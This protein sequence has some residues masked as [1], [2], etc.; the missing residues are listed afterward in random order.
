MQPHPCVAEGLKWLYIMAFAPLARR[1]LASLCLGAATSEVKVPLFCPIP[2]KTRKQISLLKDA[3]SAATSSGSDLWF[4]LH[5]QS[6]HPSDLIQLLDDITTETQPLGS[7]F[8]PLISELQL[9]VDCAS[10]VSELFATELRG[11]A[12]FLNIFDSDDTRSDVLQ[13]VF[14]ANSGPIILAFGA[15]G[16]G[17]TF[18]TRQQCINMTLA[19]HLMMLRGQLPPLSFPALSP[20]LHSSLFGSTP[21]LP[22]S[23]SPVGP[24]GTP[25]SSSSPLSP[26]SSSSPAAPPLPSGSSLSSIGAQGYLLFSAS[27]NA[28]LSDMAQELHLDVLSNCA[29]LRNQPCIL[30]VV[31]QEEAQVL[32]MTPSEDAAEFTVESLTVNHN[33]PNSKNRLSRAM[34]HG[35]GRDRNVTTVLATAGLLSPPIIQEMRGQVFFLN[36]DEAQVINFVSTLSLMSTL[37]IDALPGIFPMVQAIGDGSQRIAHTPPSLR[38]HDP[39]KVSPCAQNF[40]PMLASSLLSQPITAPVTSTRHFLFLASAHIASLSP[41]STSFSSFP[42]APTSFPPKSGLGAIDLPPIAPALPPSSSD[43]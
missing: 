34:A 26:S 7:A 35:I 42:S 12:S 11:G 37:A 22:S 5:L 15:A 4:M 9:F 14:A 16:S 21:P 29:T 36:I 30:H 2:N 25:L 31:G 28:P 17:K 32:G 18:L 19:F 6:V 13:R 10:T 24:W 3:L 40:S 1:T 41:L 23:S 39:A 20:A 8:L 27:M 38:H 33:L 43:S